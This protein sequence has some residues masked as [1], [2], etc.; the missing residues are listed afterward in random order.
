MIKKIN[1][2]D[3]IYAKWEKEGR[4]SY[5]DKPEDIQAIAEM[6]KYMQEVRR[7]YLMKDRRSQIAA[8]HV[9]LTD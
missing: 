9:V 5:F 8:S 2:I 4:I 7:E 6:N 3:A 1:D